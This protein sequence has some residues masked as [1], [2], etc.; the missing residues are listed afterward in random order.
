MARSAATYDVFTAIAEPTR[1]ELLTLLA[2]EER[3]VGELVP[4]VELDQP[5]VSK[6]LGVL[7]EVGLVDMRQDGRRRLYRTNA[8]GIKQVHDWASHFERYWRRQ[9]GRIKARAE[10]MAS[11]KST[12]N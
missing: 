11:K 12:N 7:R 8:M 9:L 2:E 10:S 6:H 3:P 4:L 5:S 1:R